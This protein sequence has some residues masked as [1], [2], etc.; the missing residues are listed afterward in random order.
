MTTTPPPEAP[1]SPHEAFV[2]QGREGTAL[3]PD[4]LHGRVE[5]SASGQTALLTSLEAL[6]AFM[7]QVR[8]SPGRVPGGECGASDDGNAR[9][10]LTTTC[11]GGQEP[12]P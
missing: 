8:T 5:H 1:L 2:V 12:V 6:Q 9:P 7:A 4:P 3:T 10:R 11:G